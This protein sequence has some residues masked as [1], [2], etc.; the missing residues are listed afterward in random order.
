MIN[1]PTR[2]TLLK[3]IWTLR[4][5]FRSLT[6]PIHKVGSNRLFLFKK[7]PKTLLRSSAKFQRSTSRYL[8]PQLSTYQKKTRQGMSF[9][10]NRIPIQFCSATSNQFWATD[11]KPE[12]TSR[13]V[14]N[15]LRDY[16][17]TKTL[18]TPW[19]ST[20]LELLLPSPSPSPHP[21]SRSQAKTKRV[22]RSSSHLEIMTPKSKTCLNGN[23]QI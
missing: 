2:Q 23:W 19:K 11:S 9:S 17:R 15:L 4:H 12:M 10:I 18:S 5:C 3:S 8:I 14:S 20:S 22:I 16:Q 1:F 13:T 6:F 7:R 21:S